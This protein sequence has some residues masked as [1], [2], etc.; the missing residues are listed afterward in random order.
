MR[1]TIPFPGPKSYTQQL[2]R[3]PSLSMMPM[4]MAAALLDV[5]VATVQGYVRRGKLVEI[6]VGNSRDW[7]GVS[8]TSVRAM[9]LDKLRPMRSL[10]QLAE[11]LLL[12]AAKQRTTIEYG[13]GLMVPLGLNPQHSRDRDLLGKSL[14]HISTRSYKHDRVLLSALAV[15]KDSGMPNT[16]FFDLARYL[17]AMPQGMSEERFLQRATLA[18]FAKHG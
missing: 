9:R 8:A 7:V 17:G 2:A 11:P 4:S 16:Q 10:A 13:A 15:R 18:V 12:R 5:E 14:G 1:Q 3:D 6:V